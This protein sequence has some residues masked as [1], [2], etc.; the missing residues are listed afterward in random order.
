MELRGKVYPTFDEAKAFALEEIEEETELTD[1]GRTLIEADLE[2]ETDVEYA[3]LLFCQILELP[4][5][6]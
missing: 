6:E 3:P 2:T 1:K 4:D 5:E